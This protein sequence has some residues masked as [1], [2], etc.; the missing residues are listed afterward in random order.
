MIGR[1]DQRITF[2]RAAD[3]SDGAGGFIRTWADVATNPTVWA[4]VKAKSGSEALV[5]GRMTASL[6]TIF[7]VWNRSDLS[8][9]DRIIWNGEAYN[10]RGILRFGGA[11]LR[12]QI[13]AERGAAS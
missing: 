11:T 5:N 9:L 8:E 7:T 4:D 12:L 6:V 13:E 10:I 1:M 3:V 2:Q